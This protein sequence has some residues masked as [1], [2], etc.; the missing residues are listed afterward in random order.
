MRTKLDIQLFITITGLIHLLV[1]Y[2]LVPN[3]SFAHWHHWK[4]WKDIFIIEIYSVLKVLID[5]IL[6]L[7]DV[8]VIR[9]LA[10]LRVPNV[11]LLLPTFSFIGMKQKNQRNIAWS[12]NF[13]F[14]IYDVFSLN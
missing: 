14:C 4:H 7:V 10:Y 2:V 8:F 11:P 13:T 3:V 5:D 12:F 9:Q 1:D 6:W